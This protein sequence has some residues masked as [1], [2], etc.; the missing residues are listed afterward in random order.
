[1]STTA[2]ERTDF[3][4]ARDELIYLFNN[5]ISRENERK[6]Y[7]VYDSQSYR[8]RREK[9]TKNELNQ[10]ENCVDTLVCDY[11]MTN[12][13]ELIKLKIYYLGTNIICRL[14]KSKLL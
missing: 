13:S 14:T 12:I 1:M 3:T 8:S 9:L 7:L 2:L 5:L 10:L 11:N 4:N 6:E